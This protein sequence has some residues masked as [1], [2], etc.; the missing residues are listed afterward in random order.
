MNFTRSIKKCES[1]VACAYMADKETIGFEHHPDRKVLYQ[2]VYSDK[3][4]K[5]LIAKH[6]D[7]DS[8]EQT[9]KVLVPK[10]STVAT[11]KNGEKQANATDKETAFDKLS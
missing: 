11:F 2:Y 8:K 6:E 9:L 5:N 10:V 3:E 4:H 7:I 1:W